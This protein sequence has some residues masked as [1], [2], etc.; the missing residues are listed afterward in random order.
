MRLV[1]SII[2]SAPVKLPMNKTLI[3]YI[4]KDSEF[5]PLYEVKPGSITTKAFIFCKYCGR[6]ISSI[7]GPN[8]D[9][10]CIPCYNQIKEFGGFE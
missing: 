5:F 8:Y 3:G 9:A 7:R 10:V 1:P 6:S 2:N 4:E